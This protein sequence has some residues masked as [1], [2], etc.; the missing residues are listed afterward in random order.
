MNIVKV[1]FIKPS[2]PT[3]LFPLIHRKKKK[4]PEDFDK[5]VC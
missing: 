3:H 4:T 1:D 5:T 2:T